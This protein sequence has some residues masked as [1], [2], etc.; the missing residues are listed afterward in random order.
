MTQDKF[1][2][3]DHDHHH[4]HHNHGDASAPIWDELACHLPYA[5]MSV[6]LGFVILSF[7]NIFTYL[8]GAS[9][10][11]ARAGGMLFH[12]FHF[13]H[14]V[15]A[16]TGTVATFLR[17]SRDTT[18]AIIVGGITSTV[19]CVV[20]D[21]LMPYV[22]GRLLGVEM[23]LH[24][25]FYRELHNIVPFLL[26]GLLNGYVLSARGEGSA[27]RYALTSHMAHI[28]VSSLASLFYLVSHGQVQWVLQ[29]G[30][31]FVLLILSV[32]IPCTLSDIVVPVWYARTRG[33]S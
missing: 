3:D 12:C 2:H 25:C 23:Q 5:V 10:S 28:L 21:I 11:V 4:H 24:I 7:V 27:A 31:I 1:F 16:A 20:S 30:P 8:P 9:T 15:F 13:L 26:V 19:F 18:K 14:I 6:A 29:M 17:H 33:R 32:V 22:A